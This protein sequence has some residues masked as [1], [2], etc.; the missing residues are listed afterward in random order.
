MKKYIILN[1]FKMRTEYKNEFIS[2]ENIKKS[3]ESVKFLT[4]NI[5]H[6]EIEIYDISKDNN[7]IDYYLIIKGEVLEINCDENYIILINDK[8]NKEVKVKNIN[9]IIDNKIF[10][11]VKQIKIRYE[12]ML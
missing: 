12:D 7:D 4:E 11:A 6:I 5:K 10:N 3:I 9:S 2:L 1:D 8:D